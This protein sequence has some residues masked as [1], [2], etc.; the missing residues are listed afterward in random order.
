MILIFRFIVL[1]S[2]VRSGQARCIITSPEP[3]IFDGSKNEKAKYN[4]TK[5]A[6]F[7]Q[8]KVRR[9]STVST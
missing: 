9:R 7:W 1:I 2:A 8:I 4:P 6:I 5:Q 3:S